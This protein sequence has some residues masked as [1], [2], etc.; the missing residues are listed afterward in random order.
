MFLVI[1]ATLNSP[2]NYFLALYAQC[3]PLSNIHP[4][5]GVWKSQKKSHSTLRAKRATFTFRVNKSWLK[6]S[7]MVHFGEFLK[8]WSLRSNS[9]TRQV[10][11][12]RTKIGGKCQNAKIRMRHFESFSNKRYTQ[13][14]LIICFGSVIVRGLTESLNRQTDKFYGFIIKKKT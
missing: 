8:T 14:T 6:M 4:T 11:F 1:V 5:N 7:K 2:A 3:S 13:K 10:S 9:V 12:N